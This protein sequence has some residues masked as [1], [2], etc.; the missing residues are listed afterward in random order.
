MIQSIPLS[1]M[2]IREEQLVNI[3]MMEFVHKDYRFTMRYQN[4]LEMLRNE[5]SKEYTRQGHK[6]VAGLKGLEIGY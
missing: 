2:H 4:Y 3:S 5:P 1:G 6:A